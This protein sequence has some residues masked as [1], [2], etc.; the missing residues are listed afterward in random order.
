MKAVNYISYELR[1]GVGNEVEC[2]FRRGEK[3]LLHLEEQAQSK[4][5]LTGKGDDVFYYADL[6]NKCVWYTAKLKNE[7]N[8]RSIVHVTI[9]RLWAT[10]H[11][12]AEK[13]QKGEQKWGWEGNVLWE[14]CL[15]IFLKYRNI[16][17][18][19]NVEEASKWGLPVLKM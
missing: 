3:V 6:Q 5:L 19:N 8:Q 4:N 13:K 12:I 18:K 9:T 16:S 17:I 1:R 10:D 14:I 7:V 11:N 2:S 15:E